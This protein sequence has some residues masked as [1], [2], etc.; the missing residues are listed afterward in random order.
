M[1]EGHFCFLGLL[2]FSVISSV[3]EQSLSNITPQGILHEMS[4]DEPGINVQ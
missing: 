2:L 1:L 4:L 3:S